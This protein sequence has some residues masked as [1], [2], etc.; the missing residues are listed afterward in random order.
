MVRGSSAEII[1]TDPPKQNFTWC[2][3]RRTDG[4]TIRKFQR[5]HTE[6]ETLLGYKLLMT[7][8]VRLSIKAADLST[9]LS[10]GDWKVKKP[11]MDTFTEKLTADKDAMKALNLFASCTR[12]WKGVI[13]EKG[14]TQFFVMGYSVLDRN[15]RSGG[16]TIIMLKPQLMGI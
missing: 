8:P 14:P 1:R 2:D 12:E 16:F 13:S 15:I 9:I 4:R 11:K 7:L 5:G 3:D 6:I 10:V